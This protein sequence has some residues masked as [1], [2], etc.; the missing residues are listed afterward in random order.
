MRIVIAGGNQ[1]ADFLIKSF[2]ADHHD[3]QVIN[4]NK[5]TAD[6]LSTSND[7]PVFL[8]DPAKIYT[9]SDAR[10]HGADV[11]IALCEHDADNYVIC[12]FAKK[13]FKV[14]KC[15]CIVQNP[16]NVS[17]FRRLDI[18]TVI[19]STYLLGQT[20]RRESALEQMI[21][22]LTIEDEK[23]VVIEISVASD[24]AIV[25]KKIMDI[26]FPK[27]INISCIFR[28][29]EIII[30]MGSTA[31]EANDKMIVVAKPSEQNEIIAFLKQKKYE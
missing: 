8:G 24:F 14:K 10:I 1:E 31:I 16:K 22:T 6:Y 26:K 30:P 15:V 12:A 20:I 18:E 19:S 27:N 29:P 13:L 3:L 21:R 2:K 7:V 4:P 23:I 17:L 25:G 9:L 28:D 11:L 5:D